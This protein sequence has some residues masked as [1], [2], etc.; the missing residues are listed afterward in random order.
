MSLAVWICDQEKNE[1]NGDPNAECAITGNIWIQDFLGYDFQMV[2]YLN[3]IP[4]FESQYMC[5]GKEL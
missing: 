4:V 3:A 5:Y 1:Y 2:L